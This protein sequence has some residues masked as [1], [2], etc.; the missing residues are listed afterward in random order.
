MQ[1]ELV[2]NEELPQVG[3]DPRLSA[4]LQ[5]PLVSEEHHNYEGQLARVVLE[6]KT[7]TSGLRMAAGMSHEISGPERMGPGSRIAG[8]ITASVD[9]TETT[10]FEA[11]TCHR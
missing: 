5:A 7:R 8:V 1:S 9:S 4:I 11:C 3:K 6:H 2:T 10:S